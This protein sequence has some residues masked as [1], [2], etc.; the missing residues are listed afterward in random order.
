MPATWTDVFG[1]II[2]STVFF[3]A[4]AGFVYVTESAKKAAA[5]VP[6]IG[7][8][9]KNTS[10]RLWLYCISCLFSLS[11]PLST[12]FSHFVHI[13][14]PSDDTPIAKRTPS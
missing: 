5:C 11:I 13:I 9:H 12:A 2:V 4:I 7:P 14:F 8:H 3:G 6:L 1:L 10:L